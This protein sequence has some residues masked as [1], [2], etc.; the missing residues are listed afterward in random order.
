MTFIP[1]V[2]IEMNQKYPDFKTQSPKPGIPVTLSTGLR[3]GTAVVQKREQY[4]IKWLN[5]PKNPNRSWACVTLYK[6]IDF[7]SCNT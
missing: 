5:F 1:A 4:K 6:S 3:Y 2:S 7:T